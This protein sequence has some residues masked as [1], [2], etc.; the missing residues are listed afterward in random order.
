MKKVVFPILLFLFFAACKK[1]H[2]DTIC[3]DAAVKWGGEPAADGFGWY[4]FDSVGGIKNY[5][6][7]NLP[8]G[9]KID[10]LSVHVCMYET[11]EKFYCM[12]PQPMNKYHITQIRR[13]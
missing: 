1:E 3:L 2:A 11:M 12:C 13:N 5:I 9:L 4:I 7:L 10:G 8:D 6:P